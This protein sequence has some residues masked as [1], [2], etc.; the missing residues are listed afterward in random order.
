MKI[1]LLIS[2]FLFRFLS[3]DS[4]LAM[5]PRHAP[6]RASAAATT[7]LNVAPPAVP[8]PHTPSHPRV[9]RGPS[10]ILFS[11]VLKHSRPVPLSCNRCVK[12]LIL[13]LKE[14]VSI[15]HSFC[16]RS[17]RGQRCTY[18]VKNRYECLSVGVA[19]ISM[20]FSCSSAL[21]FLLFFSSSSNLSVSFRCPP[22]LSVSPP[23]SR[24]VLKSTPR[25]RR[26]EGMTSLLLTSRVVK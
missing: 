24:D 17:A 21:H 11:V 1:L 10:V 14:N 25:L 18:Y 12:R 15:N 8:T 20:L 16:T 13:D 19:A 23:V 4:S 6:A 7:S 22:S 3:V 2:S 5:P 26:R 9:F